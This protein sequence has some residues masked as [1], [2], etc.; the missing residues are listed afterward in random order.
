MNPWSWLVR[1]LHRPMDSR[2]LALVRIFV[3]LALIGDLLRVAM[4]G[5]VDTYYVPFQHGGLSTF[6]DD[7]FVL[8]TLLGPWWEPTTGGPVLF[9]ISLA[10]LFFP[11]LGVG[12]WPMALLA[13]LAYAQLGHL[14]PPGDRGVDRILRTTLLILCF[15]GA[16]RRLSLSRRARQDTLPS[17]PSDLLRFFLVTVYLAAGAGKLMQTSR[18]LADSG[19]AVLYRILG[20]PLASNLDAARLAPAMPLLRVGGWGTV[21]LELSSPLILTPLCRYWAIAGALMHL[22]IATMMIL[23]MFSWGMLAMYPVLFAPWTCKL[24]DR[25]GVT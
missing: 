21:A 6:S 22:G 2:P 1:F 17:W 15:S 11:L 16:D 3:C 4:I 18:W 23:G 20:D 8:D 25:L 9:W 10:L 14:Y 5:M 12:G 24:L 13:I 19:P 7:A